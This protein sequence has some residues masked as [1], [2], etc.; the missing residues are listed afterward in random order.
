M[1]GK[2]SFAYAWNTDGMSEERERGITIDYN[3]KTIY[4]TQDYLKNNKEQ[5]MFDE[6]DEKNKNKM[7]NCD[8]D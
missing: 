3:E 8:N 6:E 2:T 7:M 5:F 1:I 4:I